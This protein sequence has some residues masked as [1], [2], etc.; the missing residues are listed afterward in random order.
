MIPWVREWYQEYKGDDFEVIGVHYPEFEYEKD[1]ENVVDATQRLEVNYPVA[2]DNNGK[3]WR[4][5][6]QRY[7]PTRYV[8]DKNGHI[9]LK[10]I[11]EGAYEETERV[12]RALMAEP[13]AVD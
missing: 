7:W 6:G 9:R 13:D 8:L 5:Y 2:I 1:Y 12:I 4:A 11:G 10:H 3:T